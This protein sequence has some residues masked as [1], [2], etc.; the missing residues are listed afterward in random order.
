MPAMRQRRRR[1]LNRRTGR[2][3]LA[4]GWPTLDQEAPPRGSRVYAAELRPGPSGPPPGY[5]AEPRP[6][7]PGPPPGY[8]A[9]PRPGPP[10][11]VPGY[12]AEPSRGRRAAG[13]FAARPVR[14]PDRPMAPR[15]RTRSRAW[16][17]TRSRRLHRAGYSAAACSVRSMTRRSLPLAA[18]QAATLRAEHE[19]AERQSRTAGACLT[20]QAPFAAR[21]CRQLPDQCPE[22]P[23]P[24][25]RRHGP[26]RQAAGRLI[27]AWPGRRLADL[28]QQGDPGAD[29]DPMPRVPWRGPRAFRPAL[30]LLCGSHVDEPREAAKIEGNDQLKPT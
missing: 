7:P 4:V 11:P 16:P 14:E 25:N 22:W 2:D 1:A 30:I 21:G 28:D 17:K 13:L 24:S 26:G 9:E 5:A 15:S 10:G 18:R 19:M 3:G 23:R 6:G 27:S 20:H 12:A 29:L 8:A